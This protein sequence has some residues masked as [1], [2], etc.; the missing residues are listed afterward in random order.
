M[1][2]LL[3]ILHFSK[4][5]WSS[6]SVSTLKSSLKDHFLSVFKLTDSYFFAPGAITIGIIAVVSC[7]HVGNYM[8]A[9]STMQCTLGTKQ[10]G[11]R[12]MLCNVLISYVTRV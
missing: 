3:Q 1:K 11:G 12:E 8:W 5:V 6:A 4:M 9:A 7:I 2:F 10:D